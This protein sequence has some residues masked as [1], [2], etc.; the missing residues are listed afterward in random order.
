MNNR[1]TRKRFEICPKLTINDVVLT[2]LLLTL[3][4]FHTFSSASIAHF[5]QVNIRWEDLHKSYLNKNSSKK[6][7]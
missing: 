6:Q 4:I 5:E 7:M 2:F 3:N 1:N